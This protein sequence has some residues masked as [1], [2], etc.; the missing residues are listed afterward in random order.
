MLCNTVQSS[1][2]HQAEVKWCKQG[3][4]QHSFNFNL[5]FPFFTECLNRKCSPRTPSDRKRKNQL[6]WSSSVQGE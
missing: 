5:G 4:T 1:S 2:A 6:M 3:C